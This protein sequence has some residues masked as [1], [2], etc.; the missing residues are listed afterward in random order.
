MDA[1]D[2]GGVGAKHGF[3]F[4]D[5]AAARYL[6]QMLS[7]KRLK[8]V[9][10]EV[11]DDIDLLYEDFTEFVQV[12]STA[13]ESN[14]TV[15]E[16]CAVSLPVK[17]KGRKA[18]KQTD[19]IVHKS[20]S[21]D[22]EVGRKVMFRLVTTRDVRAGLRYLRIPPQKR[23]GKPGELEIKTAISK[24]IGEYKSPAGRGSDFWVDN[25]YWEV[26]PSTD[27][28]EL[29]S[30]LKI[31]QAAANRG[32]YL[33]PNRDAQLIL[34]DILF[35]LT[36]KSA[37]SRKIS[38]VDDKSYLSSDFLLWFNKEIE[39]L[40]SNNIKFNSKVYSGTGAKLPSVLT[41]FLD[42]GQPKQQ[43]G[44]GVGQS[45]EKL[46]YKY[47][48]IAE[49][50]VAWLPEMLLRPGELADMEGINLMRKSALLFSRLS[51]NYED[52]ESFLGR[53]LLHSTIRQNSGSQP[54]PATLYLDG[55]S[56]SFKE[57]E[58]I[59]IVRNDN[60]PDE[61]WLGISRLAVKG[62]LE[63]T[64]TEICQKLNYLVSNDFHKQRQRILDIKEDSYLLSHDINE[65]LS[66]TTTL[67]DHISRFRFV[68]FLGYDSLHLAHEL[69]G[70]EQIAENKPLQNEEAKKLF[71]EILGRLV[72]TDKYFGSL[73][74]FIYLFPAPCVKTL[75]AEVE[76]KIKEVLNEQ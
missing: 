9:R 34:N 41:K 55:A 39:L 7:D 68:I 69:D 47:E 12:K 23:T 71:T 33:D 22:S 24:K 74:L 30:K 43:L 10:C 16:L 63:A 56:E 36:K 52:F 73:Q 58:N 75:N 18:V 38:S 61:L 17:Q 53:V 35:T 59:H 57:F 46:K 70:L 48:Y 45:Y 65:I 51:N 66:D 28:L 32:I 29:D 49:A 60:D 1:S 40:A 64:I 31:L 21:N 5:Q 4:Q 62:S 3:L 2:L 15:T 20:L 14:W 11:T 72:A 6:I 25:V 67:D 37:I 27:E 26:I 42:L 50:I 8:A 44:M 76:S 13:G 54:I 19:S